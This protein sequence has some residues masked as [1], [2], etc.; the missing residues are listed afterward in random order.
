VP[1]HI[2]AVP[3]TPQVWLGVG[4]HVSEPA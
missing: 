3:D 2:N 4:V 1:A